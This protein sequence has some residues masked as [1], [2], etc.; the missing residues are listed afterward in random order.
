MREVKLMKTSRDLRVSNTLL[1]WSGRQDSNLRPSGPKPE[2]GS[3][4][5]TQNYVFS[6]WEMLLFGLIDFGVFRSISDVFEAVWRRNG[7]KNQ[8]LKTQFEVGDLGLSGDHPAARSS[9]VSMLSASTP[10]IQ[11]SHFETLQ[12]SGGA[13][14]GQAFY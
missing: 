6:L 3:Y 7:V 5:S 14:D 1:K 9:L 10:K 8:Y 2:T 12:A 11:T 4:A 13:T